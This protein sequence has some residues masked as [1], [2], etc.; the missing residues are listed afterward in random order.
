MEYIAKITDGK[1]F[2]KRIDQIEKFDDL[3]E[4]K[5]FLA[6]KLADIIDD[7][8]DYLKVDIFDTEYKKFFENIGGK[9]KIINRYNFEFLNALYTQFYVIG[10]NQRPV[11]FEIF[12]E[13]DYEKPLPE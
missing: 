13:E 3:N 5:R 7:D 9:P 6:I 10:Y 11:L 4:A 8:L 12:A 1:P 2:K